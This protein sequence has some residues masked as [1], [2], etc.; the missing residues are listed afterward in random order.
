MIGYREIGLRLAGGG[1]ASDHPYREWIDTY[2]GDAYGAV[3][4]ASGLTLDRLW[5]SRGGEGRYA[6]LLA[7]FR[8]ATRLEAAFWSMGFAARGGTL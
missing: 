7:T 5:A 8:Q 2:A 1:V 6:G 4:A 3:A